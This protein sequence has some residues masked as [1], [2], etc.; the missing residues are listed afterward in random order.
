MNDNMPKN[1]T[2]VKSGTIISKCRECDCYDG[3]IT[4]YDALTNSIKV[5]TC[6]M[7]KGYQNENSKNYK[8][9]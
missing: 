4:K 2:S 8:P 9:T 6:P 1:G 5:T 7:C 3:K